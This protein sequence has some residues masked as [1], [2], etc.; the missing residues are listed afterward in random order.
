MRVV[1]VLKFGYGRE[2]SN[3][4]GGP[5][6]FRTSVRGR[7]RLRRHRGDDH[8]PRLLVPEVVDA[9]A[10]AWVVPVGT[11]LEVPVDGMVLASPTAHA[12]VR[13]AGEVVDALVDLANASVH[14]WFAAAEALV[15]IVV[16]EPVDAPC[17]ENHIFEHGAPQFPTHR[18]GQRHALSQILV[19]PGS[20]L[21]PLGRE[22]WREIP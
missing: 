7:L 14:V 12:A 16:G 20:E 1:T 8:A 10:V 21:L 2:G 13:V 17:G 3:L 22:G 4:D 9:E 15:P 18:A 5:D 11:A 19:A 6:R